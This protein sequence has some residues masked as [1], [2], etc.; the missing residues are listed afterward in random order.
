MPIQVIDNNI[1]FFKLTSF[2]N[3]MY[4]ANQNFYQCIIIMVKNI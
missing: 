1:D 2:S 4:F 3:T